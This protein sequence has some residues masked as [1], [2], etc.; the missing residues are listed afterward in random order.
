MHTR[1]SFPTPRH[2]RSPAVLF[3]LAICALVLM[4]WS[5]TTLGQ[6]PAPPKLTLAQ[7]E[8]LIAHGVPDSTM[9]AQIQRRGLA[10]TPTP[11]ILDELRA[12]GAGE[13]VLSAVQQQ[14]S[15]G[16]YQQQGLPALSAP[17][18][19]IPLSSLG[20]AKR[21][22]PIVLQ[23]IFRSLDQG[24]PQ[25][26]AR[27]LSPQIL[28]DP[29]QLDAICRPFNYR[30]HYIEAI[31][32]RPGPAFE[33]WVRVLFKPFEE[34]AVVMTFRQVD[35]DFQL[36][37]R[38]DS[39]DDWFASARATALQDARNFLYAAKAQQGDA[40]A[41]LVGLGIDTHTFTSGPC[42]QELLPRI[43]RV[44]SATA[45]LD[46]FK[47]LKIHVRTNSAMD[48]NNF[49]QS[50]IVS[51]FWFDR[52]GDDYKIVAATLVNNPNNSI[53]ADN[54]LP[55]CHDIDR[56]AITQFES[57]SLVNQTLARFGL[58]P[59]S[60]PPP[61]PGGVYSI[62]GRVS[63]PEVIHSV[64]AQFSD[65]ARRARYQGNCIVSLIV[66]AQGNPQ[67][68]RVGRSLGKGLDEKAIE[69]VRQ[70][71][72]KPGKLDGVT[73][74]PVSINLEIEFRLY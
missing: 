71:K 14:M 37:Q 42:W 2:F 30:A 40:L 68:I 1:L 62:G 45:S 72:F 11:D 54:S 49:F 53:M 17:A 8:S 63:A 9:S 25:S 55:A 35:R 41:G 73:P 47:G 59:S 74:V 50:E 70:Y 3:P 32:E 28:N 38:S 7:I 21:Q 65:E 23:A 26:V 24:D 15:P 52:I 44:Q 51:D 5:S 19:T 39:V 34:R 12:K 66:D 10:F 46:Q 57:P 60:E 58:S 61:P 16:S 33:A 67:D 27:Y 56:N 36:V 20:D 13:L 31:V 6:Q 48:T 64:E 43:V 29:G 4:L 18:G 22:I 69:A